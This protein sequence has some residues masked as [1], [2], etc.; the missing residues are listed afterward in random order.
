MPTPSRRRCARFIAAALCLFVFTAALAQDGLAI[1]P[2][3]G[4]LLLTGG[5]S[6]ID[7]AAG[8]GLV[9][10]A[11]TGSY[12]TEGELGA[13]AHL[14][15]IVTQ[16]YALTG[17]GA[18]VSYQDRFEVSLARQ[19]FN[20]GAVVPGTTLRLDILGVK[21]RVAGCGGSA[22]NVSTARR[23]GGLRAA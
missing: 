9:P 1:A 18:A 23:R 7:G 5:V 21:W 15:R 8:G 13:T 14:T 20:A 22:L 3:N 6:S 12:A 2:G 16:D 11:V 19:E 4:K 17:F 10:W